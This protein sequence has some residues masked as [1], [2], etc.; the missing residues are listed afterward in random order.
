MA[1]Y[2]LKRLMFAFITILVLILITFFLMHTL[3]GDPFIGDKYISE[4]TMKAL[5]AKYGLDKPLWQQFLIY[6]GN[7]FKGDLGISTKYNRPVVRILS[8]SFP[9]SAELGL[10]ALVL[11][12]TF[13]LILGIVAAIKHN[14]S[15]DTG[16]MIVAI[17]G[18]SVPSF[19]MGA[20]LQYILAIKLRAWFGISFFPV[21]GWKQ[22]TA[23]IMPAIALSLG[24][25]A[26]IARLMRT[27]MLDVL[28]QDY[29]KTAKA[30]GLSQGGIVRRHAVRN[31]ILPVVT[32]L[33]PIT[34]SVLTGTFV[35]ENIFNI[36]GM[37]KFFVLAIREND[38]T[39]I[40]GTT[41]FYG[42]FLVIATLIVDL[43]YGFIDPRIKLSKAK[44]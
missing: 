32:V 15:M 10:R 39:L 30:K 25:M 34:A 40:A 1:R 43:L 8:E 22:E 17:I 14:T 16:A 38:Y 11:A 31:A 44:E 13:G 26:T 19:I 18:V 23:K 5:Y 41:I 2:V 36:P 33:G 4:V 37:G 35:I 28:G 3:P 21:M 9:Y 7:I 29:I 42:V 12:V 6:I 27:S 20:F 24:S